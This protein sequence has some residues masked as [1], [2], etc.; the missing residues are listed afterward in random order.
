MEAK[1]MA[2][3]CGCADHPHWAGACGPMSV[4]KTEY[5]AMDE[6]IAQAARARCDELRREREER[7]SKDQARNGPRNLAEIAH[8]ISR[9]QIEASL[10]VDGAKV[11]AREVVSWLVDANHYAEGERQRIGSTLDQ[12]TSKHHEIATSI[13]KDN[14]AI[15]EIAISSKS[16]ISLLASE[17]KE[18]YWPFVLISLLGLKI[19]RV[20]YFDLLTSSARKRQTPTPEQDMGGS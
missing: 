14:A 12:M 4:N 20:N 7:L 17:I 11:A 3:P 8:L 1:E 10:D 6:S 2:L 18:N 13:R 16:G 19:A 5:T 9:L 15:A